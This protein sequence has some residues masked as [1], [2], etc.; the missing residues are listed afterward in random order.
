MHP[1]RS[2]FQGDSARGQVKKLNKVGTRKRGLLPRKTLSLIHS[3]LST[4]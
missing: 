4:W 1:C 3:V 2:P